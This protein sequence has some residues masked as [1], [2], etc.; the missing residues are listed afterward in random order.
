MVS[1]DLRKESSKGELKVATAKYYLRPNG[2]AVINL[3][4]GFDLGLERGEELVAKWDGSKL[5]LM[6]LKKVKFE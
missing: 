1:S 6:P 2:S 5:I 3:P 4:Q